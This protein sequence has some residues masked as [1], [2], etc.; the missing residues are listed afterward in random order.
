MTAPRVRFAPSPTGYL[1]VGGARTAL[2]NYLYAR[3]LGGTFVLRIED[4]DQ[5]RSTSEAA[6]QVIASMKWLGLEWD[7]GPE[8][9]GPN[10]PYYQAQRLPIYRKHL[11]RLKAAGNVY[12]C[13]CTDDEL[14]EKKKRAEAMGLPFVYDGRCRNFSSA[15]VEKRLADKTPHTWRFKA[16]PRTLAW[17]DLVRGPVTFDGKLIGDF[18]IVKS[19]G[20][21][22]YNFA[23]V[24]DDGEM[25]ISHVLRG[26]D[27]ISNTPRQILL[28]EAL[29]F[30]M[31]I[32]GHISMILGQNREKLS[33]RHGATSVLEFREQGYLSDAL[34]NHLALLGWAPEDGVEIIPRETLR[35][36][37]KNPKF[38]A[39]PAVFDYAK[40]DFL[41]GHAI[42]A[43]S[44]EA[45]WDAF[46]PFL[47]QVPGMTPALRSD[48][49]TLRTLV[50]TVRSHCHRLA[51]VGRELQ[52]FLSDD[53][54]IS[55]EL[56][57]AWLSGD[58]PKALATL[59]VKQ[60]RAGVGPHVTPDEMKAL[61][62]AAKAELQI[63]GK[64]F[65]KPI[66]VLLTGSEH[67]LELDKVLAYISRDQVLA[68]FS[69]GLT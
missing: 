53:L 33:K 56:R 64:G 4:T 45:A 35:G 30:P 50:E 48:T 44:P 62:A 8:T 54:P 31:P 55:E 23:V 7:E 24:V 22:T 9:G 42:R 57:T 13:F 12:P 11:D 69:R 39:A 58:A 60:I 16:E 65:F 3:S 25:R 2:F 46:Q 38:N 14:A 36:A 66:R 47:D 18:V 52:V 34:I 27:H 68:R 26:D 15:E 17:D 28:Y 51:D 10:E 5:V 32:F 40:L 41:N 61:Q 63:T 29:G 19:D 1:H 67:G 49:P 20:F 59:A 21:P 37:F 6:E 43:L